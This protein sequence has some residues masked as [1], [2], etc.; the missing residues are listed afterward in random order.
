M[1]PSAWDIIQSYINLK[2]YFNSPQ[3]GVSSDEIR[4][5]DGQNV[6]NAF[7]TFINQSLN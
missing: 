1:S 2:P 6:A 3:S 5:E 7:N 4:V